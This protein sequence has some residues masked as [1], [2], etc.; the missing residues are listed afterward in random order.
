MMV[1]A[2]AVVVVEEVVW[3]LIS[4]AVVYFVFSGY[5]PVLVA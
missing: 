5:S 4:T 2:A 1:A 3:G